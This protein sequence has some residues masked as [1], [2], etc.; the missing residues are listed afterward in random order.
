M[1]YLSLTEEEKKAMLGEIGVRSFDELIKDI[2]VS[3]RDPK[4]S[5]PSSLSEPEVQD[6]ISKLGRKNTSTKD[7]LSFLG[8][9]NQWHL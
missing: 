5:L 6:L 7:A 8:P 3:L 1:P 2:P 9:G 4:I